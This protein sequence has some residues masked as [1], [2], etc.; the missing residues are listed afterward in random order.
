MNLKNFQS[1]I[2]TTILQRGKAYFDEGAVSILDEAE[3]GIWCAEVEGSEV[4]S[5]EVELTDN[6]EIE[7]YSCDCPHDADVCKHIVA[8]F[9]EL[10]DRI[11]VIKLKPK[12]KKDQAL[13]FSELLKKVTVS[14]LKGF[15]ELY[16]RNDKSFKNQF[17]L[18]FANKD[19]KVDLE[20]RYSEL[21]KKAIRSSMSQGFVDYYSAGDLSGKIDNFLD[22]AKDA[23]ENQNFKDASIIARVALKQ[24][25][26]DVIPNADDSNGDIGDTISNAISVLRSIAE[27]E[28]CARELKGNMHDF[29]AKELGNDVYFDYGDFGEDC[30]EIF[31]Y[32]SVQLNRPEAFL[33]F[34]NRSVKKRTEVWADN[35][36]AEYFIKQTILFF[37]E[38]GNT[39]EAEKLIRQ[40]MD[41]VEVR[42]NV[43]NEAIN[44]KEYTEAKELIYQGII[45]AE[46]RQ[47]PGT[48]SEWQ[49]TLLRIADLEGD[50]IMQ[51]HFNLLFAFDR[52][53]EKE[54]YQK[55]KKTFAKE[56]WEAEFGS[57]IQKIVDEVELEAEKH[58][59][60]HWWS[61]NSALL[62]RLAPIYVQEKHW[63]KLYELVEAYP[64][65]EV[66]LNYMKYLAADYQT[67]LIDLLFPALLLAGDKADSRSGY[68]QIASNMQKI[69]KLMP[70]GKNKIL[71]AAQVQG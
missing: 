27:S 50:V 68:A 63:Y 54:Y 31:R 40:N 13:S 22:K 20:K 46:K 66:L 71:E 17:E 15:V 25:V 48:V 56:E 4:Y 37:Q 52:S 28:L 24:L 34:S 3:D 36:R 42:R 12:K 62:N 51:R 45:L 57:L 29:L 16:A 41:I 26:E 2:S 33:S 32:L 1:H 23:F 11:K 55:W 58:F 19:E 49:K 65:L 38:T 7:G 5:V 18:H 21:I 9:Y 67:K 8:V 61:K 39:P 70:E 35:Y 6:D 14:E 64:S 10:K 47:H 60:N 44:R 59:N 53:F 30:F 43:V 69:I